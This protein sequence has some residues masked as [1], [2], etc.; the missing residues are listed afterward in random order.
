MKKTMVKLILITLGA[1]PVLSHAGSVQTTMHV[2]ASVSY[3]QAVHISD[4]GEVKGVSEY[5]APF[6]VTHDGQYVV[7]EY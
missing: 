3:R 7:I 2:G 5:P 4:D 6:T 1:I